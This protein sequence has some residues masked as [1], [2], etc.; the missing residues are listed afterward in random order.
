MVGQPARS[1][2]VEDLKAL[3]HPLRWRILRLCLDQALTNQQLAQRLNLSPAT[4]L[5]HVRALVK[6][7][8]LEP[9]PVRTGERGALERPYRATGR[10]WGLAVLDLDEPELVQSVDLA[11]L[12]AHRSEF[13]EAGPDASRDV[14]RGIVR[15]SPESL[16]ELKQR[17]SALLTEFA[18]RQEPDGAS[19]SYLWSLVARP[20]AVPDPGR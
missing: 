15:L 7:R 4:T 19:L 12:A 10:T 8:F 9:E 11:M 6:S 13:V 14:A 17:M 2:T 20:T 3:S 5:R 18:A 16:D 1:A